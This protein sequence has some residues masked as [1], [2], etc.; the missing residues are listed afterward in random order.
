MRGFSAFSLIPDYLS[1]LSVLLT[2]DARRYPTNKSIFICVYQRSIIF[3][4]DRKNSAKPVSRGWIDCYPDGDR[5]HGHER[6]YKP[7]FFA[8][9]SVVKLQMVG[10]GSR[11]LVPPNRTNRPSP[12][13]SI[14]SSH[15]PGAFGCLRRNRS[16]RPGAPA[17]RKERAF[18]YP[19]RFW[20]P[21]C[22]RLGLPSRS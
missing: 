2:A 9:G 7:V 17:Q 10:S 11:T 18:A 20:A 21:A 22:R 6:Y 4:T 13:S 14:G 3:S 1:P 15:S 12:G 16:C 8:T 5:V 19:R